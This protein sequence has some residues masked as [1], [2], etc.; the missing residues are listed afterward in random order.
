[1]RLSASTRATETSFSGA[2]PRLVGGFTR[3]D[4]ARTA[5]LLRVLGGEVTELSSADAAELAKLHENVFRNVNIALV[6]ELAL[7]CERMGLDVWEVVGAAATK[8]FG[9]MPFWPGPG[10]GGHC[11]PVD[12][13][14]LSWRA[15][16]FGVSERF[17]ELAADV[18]GSMPDHVAELVARALERRG[19]DVGRRSRRNSGRG[20]QAKRSRRAQFPSCSGDCPAGVARRSS[21]LPRPARADAH[22]RGRGTGTSRS[23]WTSCSIR[24]TQL[25][26]PCATRLSTGSRCT[27]V[28]RW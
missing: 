17:V 23:R 12:P 19:I 10:V 20:F 8:P 26:W 22:G 18:N 15:R 3:E 13:Y 2:I 28:R 11:I 21:Q 14:Y 4:G 24:P 27:S 1:M 7:L 6:N 16:Q 9:F 5:T 25:S